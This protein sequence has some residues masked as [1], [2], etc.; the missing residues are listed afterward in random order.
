[1][2]KVKVYK[3]V[4]LWEPEDRAP[5]DWNLF[6]QWVTYNYDDGRERQH[7]YRFIWRRPNGTLQAARGQARI[8]SAEAL[9]ILTSKASKAGWFVKIESEKL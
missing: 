1:M 9:F 3:Q 4:S 2:T 8:P 6:F 5:I 7:G